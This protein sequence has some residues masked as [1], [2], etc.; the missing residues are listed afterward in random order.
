MAPPRALR[1]GFSMPILLVGVLAY[2]F[3]QWRTTTL[4]RACRWHE[5]PSRD[6]AGQRCFHCVTCQAIAHLPIG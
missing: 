1:Q 4:T 6:Q 5:D 3:W 2:L